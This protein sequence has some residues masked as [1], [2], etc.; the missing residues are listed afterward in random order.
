MGE[1]NYIYPVRVTSTYSMVCRRKRGHL[2]PIAC[3][4][5]KEQ[6]YFFCYLSRP[7]VVFGEFLSE[8]NAEKEG[9]YLDR[10]ESITPFMH[11]LG[12][13]AVRPTLLHLAESAKG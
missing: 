2:V 1:I 10:R 13:H 8:R 6:L 11:E 9:D 12:K 4:L 5:E 3:V 7:I